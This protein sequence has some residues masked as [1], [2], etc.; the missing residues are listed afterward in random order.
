MA[1]VVKAPG[2][3]LSV[4]LSRRVHLLDLCRIHYYFYS[5]RATPE[6]VP[7]EYTATLPGTPSALR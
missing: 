4:G 1:L 5:E 6:S 3:E 7:A 2:G